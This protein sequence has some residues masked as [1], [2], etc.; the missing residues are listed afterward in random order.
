MV[1]SGKKAAGV[2][3]MLGIAV[4]VVMA[5]LLPHLV[6]AADECTT[7]INKANSS[8][9]RTAFLAGGQASDLFQQY[10]TELERQQVKHSLWKM[11]VYVSDGKVRKEYSASWIEMLTGQGAK[12]R[13]AGQL[14]GVKAE[15]DD[16]SLAEA[17]RL[18]WDIVC[19]PGTPKTPPKKPVSS[20]G[21]ASQPATPIGQGDI[22]LDAKQS[23][24]QGM[25]YA[26]RADWANAINEF[27]AAIQKYPVYASAYSNRAGAY[28][29]Q[30]KFNLAMD[31]LKKAVE[32]DPKDPYIRYNM[33]ACYSTQEVPELDRAIVS[34]D[35][36]LENGFNN[37][38]AL[39]KDPDLNKLRKHPDWRKT[40]E[41]HK[42]FL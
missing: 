2:E 1:E 24:Q 5:L 15:L 22:P 18:Q 23:L 10:I 29:Q 11:H 31:D 27:T 34:L 19:V 4:L 42:V 40:L 6:T 25:Q 28:M 38:D 41:K 13:W 3:R 8:P 30:K 20:G 33:A 36:A 7:V 26:G 12:E 37:Y 9:T 35:A 32:L 39:R 21:A 16:A 14:K 17:K